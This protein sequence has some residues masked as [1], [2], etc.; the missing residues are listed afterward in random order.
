[1]AASGAIWV[2][3]GRG[4]NVHITVVPYSTAAHYA[5]VNVHGDMYKA[6]AEI[7]SLSA[8]VAKG[9]ADQGEITDMLNAHSEVPV[10]WSTPSPKKAGAGGAEAYKKWQE[11]G[12]QLNDTAAFSASEPPVH[13]PGGVKVQSWL[14][15]GAAIA[16][17]GD[18]WQQGALAVH[19]PLNKTG[20]PQEETWTVTHLASGLSVNQGIKSQ[21][22]AFQAM[23]YLNSQ[24][25]W[26]FLAS[27]G[28][29]TP[30]A[31]KTAMAT[32][33]QQVYANLP[34]A[35]LLPKPKKAAP[36]KRTTKA[37]PAP[38]PTI[39]DLV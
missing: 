30:E 37:A 12:G 36:K 33:Q 14:P 31:A 7:K 26:N 9:I 27:S 17:T 1:M 23:Q 2:K 18:A 5:H 22:E 21:R 13:L 19:Q 15:G 8:L 3:V 35:A 25:D 11:E 6:K 16:Q 28:A 39:F 20:Q 32:V 38:E 24:A 34:M 29:A 4:S 10:K